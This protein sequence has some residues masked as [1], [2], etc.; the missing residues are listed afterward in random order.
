MHDGKDG[1]TNCRNSADD[2]VFGEEVSRMSTVIVISEM[3]QLSPV[4][5]WPRLVEPLSD[6]LNVS[7]LG[8][9]L[10]FDT[11][12]QQVTDFGRLDAEELAVEL[13]DFGFGRELVNRVVGAAGLNRRTSETPMRW[14]D[15]HCDE[16]FREG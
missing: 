9:I 11:L 4:D 1:V 8:R 13:N 5:R 12:R 15:Y 6:E 3:Q 16:Y 2:D 10:D 14:R 7:G